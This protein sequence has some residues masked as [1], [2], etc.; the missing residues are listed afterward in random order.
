M[1]NLSFSSFVGHELLHCCIAEAALKGACF[2]ST[3]FFPKSE[4]NFSGDAALQQIG[5]GG[6]GY[7][8]IHKKVFE[9][10]TFVHIVHSSILMNL[11]VLHKD[12]PVL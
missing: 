8:Y 7:N 5:V 9:I 6:G 10:L 12:I 3:G 1:Y 11:W 4:F 2:K